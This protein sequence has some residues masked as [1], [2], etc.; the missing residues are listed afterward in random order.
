MKFRLTS[1]AATMY[2]AVSYCL[3]GSLGLHSK[4]TVQMECVCNMARI[5]TDMKTLEKGKNEFRIWKLYGIGNQEK[6]MG[7]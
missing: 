1:K 2:N 6:I 5:R 3:Y 7:S 4:L